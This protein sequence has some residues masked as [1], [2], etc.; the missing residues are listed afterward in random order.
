MKIAV[1]TTQGKR[2]EQQDYAGSRTWGEHTI[3]V[4]ADGMGGMSGGRMAAY[5]AVQALLEQPWD[6]TDTQERFNHAAAQVRVA[7][8]GERGGAA[9]TAAIVSERED[10]RALVRVAWVGDVMAYHSGGGVLTAL[11]HPHRYGRSMLTRCVTS[12]DG[13]GEVEISDPIRMEKSAKLLIATEIWPFLRRRVENAAPALIERAI[14]SR[15][16]SDNATV[17]VVGRR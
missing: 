13:C 9:V 6:V 14:M 12:Y 8:K 7:L 11:T 15:H 16:F 1:A 3:A 2:P 17:L 5:T 10:G 4:V